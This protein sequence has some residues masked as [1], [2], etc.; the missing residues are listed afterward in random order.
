[1]SSSHQFASKSSDGEIPSKS[2]S[3]ATS[4]ALPLRM[5][6]LSFQ[7]ISMNISC[8]YTTW[9]STLDCTV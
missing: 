1:M 9:T 7:S 6:F 4:G 5:Q 3:T 8:I 2:I